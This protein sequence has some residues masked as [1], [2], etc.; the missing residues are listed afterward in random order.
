MATR[1]SGIDDAQIREAVRRLNELPGYIAS[2]RQ[3]LLKYA[4]HPMLESAKQKAP[5]SERPHKR[6]KGGEVVAVYKPGNL[7]RSLRF[8][9]F[10]RAKSKVYIGPILGKNTK[11]EVDGWYAHFVEFGTSRQSAQPYMRPAFLENREEA[12]ARLGKA[13]SRHIKPWEAKLSR[14]RKRR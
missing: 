9:P 4:A 14:N 1:T 5:K 2:E 13:L 6:Y 11:S 7:R 8:L 12:V 3:R 10:R